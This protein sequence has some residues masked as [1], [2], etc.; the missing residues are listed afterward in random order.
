MK[1][2]LLLVFITILS[3]SVVGQKMKF[4]VTGVP[5]T[6]VHLIKY[7]G[8]KLLYA[9]TAF[10]KN[11]MVEFNGSKQEAGI[12]GLLLPD[13]KYFEFIYNAEPEL[14][15]ETDMKDFIK[16]MKVKKSAE[17]QVFFAYIHFLSDKKTFANKLVEDRNSQTEGTPEYEAISEKINSISK[18]VLVYQKKLIADNSDKLV[19]KI[20][21]M[22]LEVV[23]PEAPVDVDGK[24]LDSLFN[25]HYFFGHY[26]DNIDFTDDRLVNTPIFGNKLDQY[27]SKTVMLQHWDTIVKYSFKFCDNLNPKSKMFQYAVTEIILKY[28]KSKIMGM[29]K[30][31]VYMLDRY[32][33]ARNADGKSP[34]YWMTEDKLESV[35]EHMDG[36]KNTV[37]GVAP[38]NISLRDTTDQNW[39]D[40]YS[41]D[42]EYKVLYFWS[43]DC[44]HCKKVTP[45][46]E[47][48][49]TEKFKGRNVEVFAVSK[50]VGAD[51][52]LWKKFSRENKLTFTNVAVTQSLYT[53]AQSNPQAVVPQYT[54]FDALNYHLT[55]DIFATPRVIVLDKNNVIIA[56]Q[57]TISQLEDFIDRMQ[58]LTDATKLFPPDPEEEES[59]KD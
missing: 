10:M 3:S 35:C 49:Y 15:L 45:K 9:D 54:T 18:E 39:A 1:N 46:L 38:P 32:Y 20:V 56:K 25:Y 47:Q 6:T 17:N 36:K 29:D 44:G 7:Y 5:D 11:G 37:L 23:I 26:F 2:F 41:L 58:K 16:E 4:K 14:Y 34:A 24:K 48:L 33:C 40:F 12:M 57:L 22:S 50:A 51:F 59:M 42:A 53:L 19:S 31:P 13:Q 28:Q 52:E 8:K 55:Y 30:V 27:F 43:P 21:N